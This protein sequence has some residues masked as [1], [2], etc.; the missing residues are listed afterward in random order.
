[1]KRTR[2]LVARPEKANF[3][4]FLGGAV[5]KFEDKQI[6]YSQDNAANMIF[7]I[8]EGDVMLTV[9]SKGR[10]PAVIAVLGAG[11]FFGQFCLTNFPL[12]VCTATAVGSCSIL[13]IQKKQMIRILHDNRVA[14][15]LFVSFLLSAIRNYQKQ[16]VDLLVNSAE[17]RLAHALLHLAQLSP[18]GAAI[19]RI[20]Q[21]VLGNMIGATRSRTNF[22]MNRF[23]R[24]GLVRYNGE[25]EILRPLR[26]MYLRH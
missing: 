4:N 5:S 20:N 18:K 16:L 7:L 9:R 22:I 26:A 17:E 15:D 1:M 23:K 8:Q 13:A 3:K 11:D 2:A 6:I 21:S 12:R 19:P 14:S 25:I 10:R 24:E